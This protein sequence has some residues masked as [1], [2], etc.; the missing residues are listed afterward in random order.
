MRQLTKEVVDKVVA[1][2]PGPVKRC[3][4]V[5]RF[6]LAGGFIRSI[7]E[8][9]EPN[10]ID[11]WVPSREKAEYYS[12]LLSGA[13]KKGRFITRNSISLPSLR[14]QFV[15]RWMFDNPATLIDS[16]DFTIAQAAV[17]WDGDR[18]VGVCS[19]TFLEDT[20]AKKLVYTSPVREE[21]PAGSLLRVKKFLGRGF[22]IS[23]DDLAKVVARVGQA[24]SK[25][26]AFTLNVDNPVDYVEPYRRVIRGAR[27]SG[28]Y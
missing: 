27:V 24:A 28:G 12:K 10:D 3:L 7:V 23:D 25:E 1:T 5:S 16:F 15:T 8:G 11:L 19:D 18:W 6:F 4:R 26:T 13:I 21:D 9:S 20:L 14:V 22:T 17:Y 2:L